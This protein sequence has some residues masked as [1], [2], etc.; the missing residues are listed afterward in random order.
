[1]TKDGQ[2]HFQPDWRCVSVAI[3]S[4]THVLVTGGLPGRAGKVAIVSATPQEQTLGK[5]LVYGIAAHPDSNVAAAACHDGQVFELDLTSSALTLLGRHNGIARCVAYSPDGTQIISAGLDGALLAKIRHSDEPPKRW[6]EHTA[7]VDCVAIHPETSVVAS[8]SRDARVRLHT[9]AGR[10]IR[11]YRGLGMEDEPVAGRLEA[12]VMCLLWVGK[13]LLAG[14]SNGSVYE[15]SSSDS[16][17]E[18]LLQLDSGPIHALASHGQ[19]LVIGA[20]RIIRQK[21][22]R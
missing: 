12:H 10:L 2:T 16:Q 5:D 8:G 19:E 20:N 15:L 9:L 6:H 1:M 13:R 21:L 22:S 4:E 3:L 14:T 17:W 18:R 7:G 11:T